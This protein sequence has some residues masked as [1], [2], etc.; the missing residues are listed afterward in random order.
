MLAMLLTSS[1]AGGTQQEILEQ[2][3]V[4]VNG[5][6]LTKSQIDERVRV[7]RGLAADAVAPDGPDA[8]LLANPDVLPGILSDAV[9]ELLLLQRADDLAIG[10]AESEIDGMLVTIKAQSNVETDEAFEALLTA[11]GITLASLRERARRQM[12]IERTRQQLFRRISVTDEEARRYFD[13][14]RREF[15]YPASVTF[16]ELFVAIPPHGLSLDTIRDAALVKFVAA[17][18][19]LAKGMDFDQAARE[20]SE[21]PS[22]ADGGLVK[23]T[24]LDHLDPAVRKALAA[25]R[26]GVVSHPVRTGDGYRFLKL[27]A[28]TASVASVFSEAR[29]EILQQLLETRRNEALEALL[30]RLRGS[31]TLEWKRA[32]F[33]ALYDQRPRYR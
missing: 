12:L 3:V 23:A 26:P 31:A 32:D 21:A 13:A 33:A 11:E 27:E 14:H 8:P 1:G 16:R 18:D 20:Y 25:L 28:V 10:V 7:T 6:L 29:D 22:G 2:I 5:D 15:A 30:T 17:G 19:R 4:K 24:V 9:D